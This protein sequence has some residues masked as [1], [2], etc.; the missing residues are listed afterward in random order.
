MN[1]EDL[2]DEERWRYVDLGGRIGEDHLCFLLD[3]ISAEV[4][5]EQISKPENIKY[6]M[7]ISILCGM[8]AH[9][10]AE[11]NDKDQ[12]EGSLNDAIEAIRVQ[13]EV[14]SK[15]KEKQNVEKTNR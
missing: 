9:F 15:L 13:T 5:T 4:E 1:L 6:I 7:A 12:I 11:S 8:V 2:A 3:R 10:L 14:L